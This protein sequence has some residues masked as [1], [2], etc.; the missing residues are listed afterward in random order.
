MTINYKNK[1]LKYKQKYLELV[2]G[3]RCNL[4]QKALARSLSIFPK[5]IKKIKRQINTTDCQ[6]L[7]IA[8]LKDTIKTSNEQLLEL[9]SK[10]NWD[11]D[12]IEKLFKFYE[13]INCDFCDIYKDLLP[14][15]LKDY[16]RLISV[17]K[18]TND[19][20]FTVNAISIYNDTVEKLKYATD[21]YLSGVPKRAVISGKKFEEELHSLGFELKNV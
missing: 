7:A 10:L 4:R 1:Y 18:I 15:F 13:F 16:D 20:Q 14:D 21:K 8:R 2:G 17:Y 19:V 12:T 5:D 3:S 11:V 9:L 6:A